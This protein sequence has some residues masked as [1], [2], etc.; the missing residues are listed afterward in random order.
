MLPSGETVRPGYGRNAIRIRAIDGLVR[1]ATRQRIG[2]DA[3]AE[4]TSP[5]SH[6]T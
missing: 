3:I 5:F 6:G 4:V 1:V 2:K